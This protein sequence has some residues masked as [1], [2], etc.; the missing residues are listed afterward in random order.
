VRERWIEFKNKEEKINEE[1]GKVA[2]EE[3]KRRK[4]TQDKSFALLSK[5]DKE[6]V[7][8]RK[9]RY[10]KEKKMSGKTK[11]KDKLGWFRSNSVKEWNWFFF[12]GKWFVMGK[13]C[14]K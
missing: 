14:W 1:G 2:K 10:Y 6:L 11:E 12:C 5:R 4:N 13:K 7:E 9:E 8:N 3:W